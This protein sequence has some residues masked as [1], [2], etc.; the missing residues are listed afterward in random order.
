MI[1]FYL[2]LAILGTFIPYAAFVPWLVQ[3]G[4]NIPLFFA[5][6]MANPISIFA[7]LDVFLAAIAL[8]GFILHD[9]QKN[10]V[11][12]RFIAIIGAL[13]VGVSCGLPL[14][15]YLRERQ[16]CAEPSRSE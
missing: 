9:G 14:Y 6:M 11:K 13:S 3:N 8:L 10:Q 2:V 12:W 7:W 5:E 15:L 16:R 1:I 4:F